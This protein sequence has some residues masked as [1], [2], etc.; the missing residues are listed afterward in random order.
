VRTHDGRGDDV[1]AKTEA[2]AARD[3]RAL[4]QFRR[5]LRVFLRFSEEAARGAGLTP[6]QHQLLLAVKGF[7]AER[8]ELP[9][10]GDA[11]EWLQLKHH[12]AVELAD[13][14]VAAGLLERQDDP[15]DARRHLLALTDEGEAKLAGLSWMH[16]DELRRFRTEVLAHLADL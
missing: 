2:L 11:A 10:I 15:T 3:Y 12:S 1:T 8:D 13:R 16:R 6:A 5:S 7:V 14:A 9:S 4:A